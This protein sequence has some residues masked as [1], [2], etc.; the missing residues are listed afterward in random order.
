M[1]RRVVGKCVMRKY[2]DVA[3]RALRPHQLG[4]GAPGGA[5]V[6][7]HPVRRWRGEAGLEDCLVK[8]DMKNAFNAVDRNKILVRTRERCR[9]MLPYAKACLGRPSELV[10][11]G[12]V[13]MSEEGTPPGDPGSALPLDMAIHDDV[14]MAA[15]GVGV[16]FNL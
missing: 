10:G 5:D 16:D 15:E 7:V 4:V 6:I 8:V 3:A 9:E 13:V 12:Y 14:V 1:V 2:G 11:D